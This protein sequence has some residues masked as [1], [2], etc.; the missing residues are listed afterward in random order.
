MS[1]I[2]LF[3]MKKTDIYS[4]K[5]L[6]KDVIQQIGTRLNNGELCVVPTETV[7]GLAGNGLDASTI[8]KIYAA[9]GRPSD[10]PLI[11][12]VASP[13]MVETIAAS[14]SKEAH[15][16]MRTFWP[17]PLTIVFK[18]QSHV[19]DAVT[20]GLDTVAVRMPA[21]PLTLKIIE[22]AQVPLAAPSANLSGRP[23]ST[24]FSHVYEDLNGRVD[25]IIDDADSSIGIES[26]VVDCSGETVTILRPGQIDQASLEIIL[27]HPVPYASHQGG[28]PKSPGVKYGHYQP[29][30]AV[31]L[32]LGEWE[33]ILA[34][35]KTLSFSKY[36]RIIAP[37]EWAESLF[38]F[39]VI[40]MG[41][42][43]D[44]DSIMKALY[45]T[46]RQMDDEGVTQI[47]LLASGSWPE[48]LLDRMKKAAN[49]NIRDL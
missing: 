31:E 41:S 33:D 13:A 9:K 27:K 15:A 22:A 8:E 7:Y 37:K 48:A 44:F 29:R 20:G 2:H 23:S 19:P 1:V 30:G 21:H 49:Q 25:M 6:T 4:S 10:N 14:I 11:L 47:Y 28:T 39:P 46:L 5:S 26:T 17:G 38:S 3:M 12:H 36:T 32:L 16:L 18:K 40:Q 42:T 43:H 35:L 34:Y 24:R 45:A